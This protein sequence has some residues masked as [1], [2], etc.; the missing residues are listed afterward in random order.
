MSFAERLKKAR[1]DKAL[2]QSELGKAVGVHYTQIGRY[3]NKGSQPS[4][5]VLSKIADAL[6]TSTDFLM[7]GSREE[8]AG[9]IGDKELV[10]QFKRITNLPDDKKMIVKELLDAFL[11]KNEVQQKLVS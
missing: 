4:A 10:N 8:L 3:E 7:F 1:I 5:D 6:D 11:F 9:G 2:S